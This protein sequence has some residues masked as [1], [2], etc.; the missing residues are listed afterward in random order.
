MMPGWYTPG[1]GGQREFPSGWLD[2]VMIV[3][4]LVGLIALVAMVVMFVV[5]IVT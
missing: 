5:R 4:L 3:S 1:M 2:G